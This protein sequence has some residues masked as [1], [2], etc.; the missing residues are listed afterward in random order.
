MKLGR[1]IKDIRTA[2]GMSQE[3]LEAKS[4]VARSV[5]QRLESGKANPT[6][7]SLEP[8]AKAL[9]VSVQIGFGVSSSTPK[10]SQPQD[11]PVFLRSAQVLQWLAE[12]GPVRQAVV[13]YLL[14]KDV[15]YLD[16]LDPKTSQAVQLLAKVP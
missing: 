2:K 5:I 13:L 12:S 1:K 11:E 8:L 10:I 9:G 6:M 15:S 16:S 14:S 7:N 4:G 3:E